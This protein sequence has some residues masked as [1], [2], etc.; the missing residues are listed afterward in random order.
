MG[1]QH[2]FFFNSGIGG[3]GKGGGFLMANQLTLTN[4]TIALNF[5]VNGSG[6]KGGMN[7]NALGGGIFNS[8]SA[9]STVV[10]V[11]IASKTYVSKEPMPLAVVSTPGV[12]AGFQMANTTNSAL[13]LRNS[14]V[15]GTNSNAY[16]PITDDGFNICSDNSAGLNGGSSL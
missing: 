8:S 9:T 11:T 16:G 4:C 15:A 13:H 3:D 1:K 6:T 10:N 14:I 7:G 12:A 2:S 5:A